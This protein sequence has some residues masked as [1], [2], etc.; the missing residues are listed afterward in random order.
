MQLAGQLFEEAGGG[1]YDGAPHAERTTAR[2]T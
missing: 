1:L 2:D